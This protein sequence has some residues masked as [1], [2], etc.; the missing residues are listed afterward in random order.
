MRMARFLHISC[1]HTHMANR[2]NLWVAG[3]KLIL[4]TFMNPRLRE[5]LCLP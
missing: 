5:M 4:S 1:I 3:H 2:C